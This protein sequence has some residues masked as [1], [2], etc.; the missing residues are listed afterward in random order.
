[1]FT[2]I[3]QIV[4]VKCNV[5][6][7]S[8][9]FYDEKYCLLLRILLEIEKEPELTSSVLSQTDSMFPVWNYFSNLEKSI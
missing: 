3:V 5:Y 8:T 6:S 7:I 4:K 1:M 2:G 9:A